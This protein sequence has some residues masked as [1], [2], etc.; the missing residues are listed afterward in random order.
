[1][2]SVRFSPIEEGSKGAARFIGET[3]N[4]GVRMI[5][6]EAPFEWVHGR[7]YA[8]E[9]R[10]RTGP[11]EA[12]TFK[13]DLLRN[14]GGDLVGGTQLTFTIEVT[15]R[16][17]LFKPIARVSAR[18]VLARI[19][20]VGQQ[21]DAYVCENAP[22][23]FEEPVGGS[24]EELLE[25]CVK[26]LTVAGIDEAL[27]AKLGELVRRA[28]DADLVRMRP[29]EVAD[30]WKINRLKVL[31][32]MLGSVPAGLLELRWGIICPSCRTASEQ[33]DNLGEIEV[34]GHCQL[35]NISFDLD[36]DKSIEATFIPHP[37]IRQVPK[38][39]FCI[40][41][42]ART[43][44]VLVQTS[45]GAGEARAIEVP[46]EQGRYRFFSR[47]GPSAMVEVESGASEEGEIIIKE[48]KLSVAEIH[49]APGAKLGIRND[50]H[51]SRHAKIERIGW[52]S[53]A[54]TAHIVSMIPEFRRIFS[55]QLLKRGTRLKVQRVA[56]LFSDLT[57]STALYTKVG[58]A[59][60]FRLVDDH[61]DLLRSAF[62]SHSGV[63]VKTMGDA[64]LSVFTD[65]TQCVRAA[66]EALS[67]SKSFE[68]PTK[69]DP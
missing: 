4:G 52:T 38:Q 16:H 8:V 25:R 45:V 61:F 63:V 60:A 40:G 22:N 33:S 34:P 13:V 6:E 28:P 11:L 62:E 21:I 53:T 49:L 64:V 68:R 51:E 39:M 66:I 41:G 31:R 18:R 42:P 50:T 32:A 56:I 23:P 7:S 44:H 1:M 30:T 35:C 24:N 5:Y 55:S 57:G 67:S 26:E 46:E 54:A 43:P 65:S 59:A 36:L 29:F 10:M 12:Y 2:S 9:R 47:G 17:W 37:A 3:R 20:E 48:G 14:T 58:D 15:P 19:T 69:M 27:A